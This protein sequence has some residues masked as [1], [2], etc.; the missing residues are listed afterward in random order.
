MFHIALPVA[1][2]LAQKA[3]PAYHLWQAASA[4]AGALLTE[5]EGKAVTNSAQDD[6]PDPTTANPTFGS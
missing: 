6:D 3:L 5:S 1:W 4:I 2:E